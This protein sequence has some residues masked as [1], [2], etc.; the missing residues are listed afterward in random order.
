[1]PVDKME[2]KPNF[3]KTNS[4]SATLKATLD[5]GEDFKPLGQTLVLDMGGAQI[6][7]ALDKNGRGVSTSNTARLIFNKRTRVWTLK[8]RLRQGDWHTNWASYGLV[9]ATIE[10]PGQA[11]TL[12]VVVLVGD[13]GFAANRSL[14]YTADTHK[15]GLAK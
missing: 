11:V 4:D 10:N 9:D 14:S 13:L 12:P 5:L 2:L 15:T 1:M 3:A 8:V 7:F 6:Q